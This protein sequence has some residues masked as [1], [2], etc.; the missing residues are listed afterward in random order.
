M[1]VGDQLISELINQVGT[2][3]SA[4]ITSLFG[5]FVTPFLTAVAGIFGL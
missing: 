4:W 5:A 2:L 1:S 3:L